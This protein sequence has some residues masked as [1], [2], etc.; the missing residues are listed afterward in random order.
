MSPRSL[1][2][3][4]LTHLC[5]LQASPAKDWHIT[6]EGAGS[7]D[8][9]SWTQALGSDGVAKAFAEAAP[10]D[11][12]LLGSGEFR[13]SNLSLKASG[14]AQKPVTIQGVDRG[15]GLPVFTA[16]WTIEK[17]DKGAIAVSLAPSLSHVTV[18]DLVFRGY[19]IAV[20]AGAA[21]ET[22]VRTGLTFENV[23][24]EQVR[25]GF[26]LA[27]CT[28]LRLT[29]CTTRRYSKHAFRFDAGCTDVKLKECVADCSE[30][31]TAWEEKTELFPFGFTLN[32]GGAP[33]KRFVFEDCVAKNN[34]MPLQKPRYKNGDGIV[35]EGNSEDVTFLRCKSLRNQDGGFDLK[36]RDVKLESCVAIGNKRDIRIW[37]GGTVR[38]CIAGWSNAGLWWKDAP[39]TVENTTVIGWRHAAADSGDTTHP[40]TLSKCLIVPGEKKGLK[41]TPLIVQ[42]DTKV[43]NDL[44]E[45]GFT[46]PVATWNG[47]GAAMDSKKFPAYGYSSQRVPKR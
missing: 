1:A 22:G 42:Q 46:N 27:D 15:K 35:V 43:L 36:V 37:R 38:N 31:D 10:G 25:H 9:S 4:L 34:M 2:A 21:G 24:M 30:G 47:E 5:L 16:G 11:R 20:R 32:D 29:K 18:K 17:P 39:I 44:A 6:P 14:Q 19:M 13:L 8:G 40:I 12:V 7:K 41:E 28:Q 26:Y 23:L 33:N 3:V 45:A